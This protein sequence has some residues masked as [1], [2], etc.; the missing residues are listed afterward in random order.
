MEFI[1]MIKLNEVGA[2]V[3]RDATGNWLVKCGIYLPGVTFDKGYRLKLRV[4]HEQDQFIRGIEPRDFWMN[5]QN[6]S[7]L[8]RWETTVPLTLGG[9]IGHFGQVGRYLYRY[10]L[11]RGNRDV[12]FWFSD[13]FGWDVGL[14]TLSAFTVDNNPQPF[15]WTDGGFRVPE[16]DGMVVYELNVREF[17]RDFQG[18]ITQL[19]YLNEL[20]VNVI[21]CMPVTNVKEDTEWG[22]TPLNFF[23]PDERLGGAEGMKRLVNAC[24]ERGI[25]VIVD[26]VYAH[27][28]PE[29]P[30]N[31]VYEASGEPNCM[32]GYF[33]GEFFAGRPGMDYRKPFTRDYFFELNHYW[34][35]EYHVDGFRYDYVPGMYD[36][37]AGQGYAELVYRTYQHST[38]IPRFRD[39]AGRSKLIQCAEHLPD[40]KGIISQTYSNCCWQNGLLE[41]SRDM[42]RWNYV[43]ENFPR[44]LD[45]ELLGYASEYSNPVTGES[46]PI[47][48]FQYL[49]SHDHK[50]FIN[51]FGELP[52]T[53]LLGEPYGDRNQF[54]KLQPYIIAL[55]TAK[56][57]PMLWQG[58]EFGE[59]WGVPGGGFGRNL[60]ERPLHWEYFY[61][62]PGKALIRL[63]R[64]MGNLRRRHRALGSRGYYYYYNNQDHLKQ[65][66]IAYR[67]QA[68]AEAGQPAEILMVILNFSAQ[69]AEVW[70][71]FPAAG[72]W[73]EE[74][75]GAR[76]VQVI[77]N[78]E[79][80][81]VRIPSHYGSVYLRQ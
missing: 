53:D 30:Y 65:G 47:A 27:A 60:Y 38:G 35:D 58:Q 57:I 59:N 25:A 37:P 45:P 2:T 44:L 6:D 39:P 70:V 71:P 18:V 28:H 77:Q 61:D 81:L 63:H 9:G 5:W 12:A 26:A 51:A 54:Y 75:D 33:E 24:H 62:I 52:L 56:G 23:A 50:R 22:Y 1:I 36:G 46:F 49:E 13:P 73:V 48:P 41:R 29:F 67:R 17:N 76:S 4:I 78:D 79:W 34:L 80:L 21:E 15:Q 10:Q 43:D 40:P 20:G 14:G 8:D 32:M 69:E 16:V 7:A 68:E 55:Y 11:L 3:E 72:R 64:V 19:D 31:L 42:V 74:I 66:V